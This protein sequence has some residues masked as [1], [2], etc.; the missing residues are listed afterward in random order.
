MSEFATTASL[1]IDVS[2]SSLND[3]R[4]TIE[5]EIGAVTV[6]VDGGTGLAESVT[7]DADGGGAVTDGGTGLADGSGQAE[8]L[9]EEQLVVLEEIHETL[10]DGERRS[11]LNSVQGGAVGGALL[12][13]GGLGAG[14][15][16][17]AAAGGVAGAGLL[18]MLTG[19]KLDPEDP[20]GDFQSDPV[21]QMIQDA[22]QRIGPSDLG[23]F[24]D[25][26][27]DTLL[28]AVDPLGIGRTIAS[29]LGNRLGEIDVSGITSDLVSAGESV[30][31]A[32][33]NLE[34]PGSPSQVLQSIVQTF[35]GIEWPD[36][37]MSNISGEVESVLDR[38]FGVEFGGGGGGSPD[39]PTPPKG[40][41]PGG[42]PFNTEDG[43]GVPSGFADAMSDRSGIAPPSTIQ[44]ENNVEIDSERIQREIREV[45]RDTERELEDIRREMQGRSPHR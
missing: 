29:G 22:W 24:T 34:W 43:N 21:V 25:V 45:A 37:T 7:R 26:F 23:S 13:A 6:D 27:K 14:G 36:L 40:R 32:F 15:L 12:G 19:G 42:N 39:V 11:F 16:G 20:A 28:T 5:D 41:Y 3:A 8:T 30:L 33:D 1:E 9:L 10:D 18:G 38:L 44:V 35:E 31:G 17:A 2:S 4:S